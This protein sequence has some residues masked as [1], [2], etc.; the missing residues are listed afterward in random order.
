MNYWSQVDKKGFKIIKKVLSTEDTSRIRKNLDD[1]FTRKP[2]LRMLNLEDSLKSIGTS[3]VEKIQVNSSLTTSISSLF[4]D[5]DWQF[6]NDFQVL[7]NVTARKEGGWHA[8]C[9][10]QYSMTDLN[11]DMSLENYRFLKIGLYFQGKECPFGS[12][13][14]V[15]PY[16]H[17]LPKWAYSLLTFILNKTF[18]G[19]FLSKLLAIKIDN[20]I[21]PGD[22]ILFDCRLIHR[23]APTRIMTH[24][25]DLYESI[26]GS[27]KIHLPGKNKYA[28]YFEVGNTDSCMQF[29]KTNARRIKDDKDNFFIEYLSK[30]SD[31]FYSIFS[32]NYRKQL[33]GRIAFLSAEDLK[34]ELG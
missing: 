17:L 18:V 13:I 28:F 33:S 24:E 7:K 16:S 10:S 14:E 34:S 30:S 25:E 6:V 12:S 2:S 11:R 23:S 5:G 8:D 32:E 20:F 22:C 26:D 21:E 29:L 19:K 1:F 31:Y 9:N 4:P 15:I 3:F 27:F